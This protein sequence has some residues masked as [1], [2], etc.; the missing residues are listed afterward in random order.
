MN[1]VSAYHRN[2]GQHR[3]MQM[4]NDRL[5][6]ERAAGR[7]VV[8]IIDEAQA[9]PEECLEAIRLLTNLETEKSK[10]LQVVSVGQPELDTTSRQSLSAS[11]SLNGSPSPIC[12]RPM[13]DQ[14]GLWLS[15]A[16]PCRGRL[17]GAATL[18]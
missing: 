9:L 4:I 10:L 18:Q 17:P 11:A 6:E 1:W 14:G 12:L 2:M 3:V 5:V 8:L 16:P 7:Q 15:V 13:D